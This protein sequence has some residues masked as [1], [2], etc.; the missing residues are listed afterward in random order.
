[1]TG[2]TQPTPA[3]VFDEL[4]GPTLFAPMAARLLDRAAPRPGERVLDLACGTGT[5]ARLAAPR[6]GPT[7]QVTAVDRNP[8]MLAVARAHPAPD[9]APIEW[10]EG[11]AT[12]LDLPDGAFDLVLCQQ[13]LQFF[14]DRPAAAAEMRRVLAAGGRAAV[15][16]WQ[17]LEQH[18]LFEAMVASQVKRLGVDYADMASPWGFPDGDAV[19]AVLS[20][21]GFARVEV[22]SVM[23]PIYFPSIERVVFWDLYATVALLPHFN[24]NDELARAD[25][26]AGIQA[27]I[28]PVVERY[29]EGAGVRFEAWTNVALAHT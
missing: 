6:L 10:R 25:L 9:G 15:S 13:G 28:A 14:P 21:A 29:R 26:L 18:P 5:V 19:H 24:W 12:A 11:D 23:V 8:R 3:Q 20:Q 2:N 4:Y 17:A 22:S 27:D 16:T 1:M 7:G